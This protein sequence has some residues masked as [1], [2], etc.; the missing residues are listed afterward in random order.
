VKSTP[1]SAVKPPNRLVT[2]RTSSS[3]SAIIAPCAA[4]RHRPSP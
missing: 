2:P 4:A 3:A 1:S